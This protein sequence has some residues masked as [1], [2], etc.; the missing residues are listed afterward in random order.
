LTK[1]YAARLGDRVSRLDAFADQLPFLLRHR[2]PDM[3]REVVAVLPQFGDYEVHA[4]LHESTDEV[5]I[6]RQSVEPRDDQRVSHSP[7]LPKRLGESW[8]QQQGVCAPSCLDIL[9]PRLDSKILASAESLD[10]ETLRLQ[11]QSAA[12]LLLSADS[13]ISDSAFHF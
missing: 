10:L 4:M 6:P 1:L 7:G 9:V 3:Q 8:A 2:S 11:S 12:T 5:Q 13:Q